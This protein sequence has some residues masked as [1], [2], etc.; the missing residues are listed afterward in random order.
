MRLIPS[1]TWC[2]RGVLLA[3]CG[4]SA[5]AATESDWGHGVS[6]VYRQ[7]DGVALATPG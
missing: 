1:I 4:A 2:G 7:E 6:L 3:L 5:L